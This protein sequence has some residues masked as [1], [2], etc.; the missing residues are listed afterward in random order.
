MG[1]PDTTT[2]ATTPDA[3]GA[4]AVA[5]VDPGMTDDQIKDAIR[6]RYIA[7]ADDAATEFLAD[8]HFQAKSLEEFKSLLQTAPLGF[9]VS[10]DFADRFARLRTEVIDEIA[11]E[12]IP[13]PGSKPLYLV[14]S[15][16]PAPTKKNVERGADPVGLFDG[17]F[18]YAVV[19]I[20]LKG[21]GQDFL[22]VRQYS[23]LATYSGPLGSNWDHNYNLWLS[24]PP[25]RLKIQRSDGA[26][27]VDSFTRHETL[28]YW[29]PP[30]GV[31]GVLLA[32]GDSFTLR[33][34][35]GTRVAYQPH[36]TLGPAIHLVARIE[37]P[38]GND[39][40]FFYDNSRLV[41][42]GVNHAERFVTFAYD[43]QDRIA[44]IRDFTSRAWR[45]DYDDAGN[46]S[47]VTLPA[48]D[49]NKR[50]PTTLYDYLG[51]MT[52]DEGLSHALVTIFDAN[53]RPFLENEYGTDAG[54]VSFR[55]VVRQRQGGG[56]TL[57]DYADVV[58]DFDQPYDDHER[59]ARQT[60]VTERDGRQMRY[61]FNRFGNMLYQ[62][63][64]AFLDG[65]PKLISTH[66][67]YNRD[68]N[69]IASAS[70]IGV[71]IQTLFGRDFYER[72]HPRGADYRPEA[73][74]NLTIEA[75]LQ[76]GN[77][78]AVVKRGTFRTFAPGGSAPGLWSA[79]ALP[80]I[81][82]TDATDAI[83]K[84]TYEP[85]F[86][87]PLTVSDPRFTRSANPAFDEDAEYQRRLTRYTYSPGN[88]FQSLRLQSVQRPTPT[89]PDGTAGQPVVTTFLQYDDR[90]RLLLVANP[91]G[92]QTQ[93]IYFSAADG[94]L[95]G[96]LKAMTIDPAGAALTTAMDRDV[97]G[98]VTRLFRPKHRSGDDDR[99][100]SEAEYN[101]LSQVVRQ[102]STGPFRIT[103][104][105]AYDRA[106]NLAR[107]ELG[108]KD[109]ANTPSGLL[110]TANRYD[111][112]A[113]LVRQ[114]IGDENQSQS[115]T[116]K[117]V[118]DRASRPC[119]TIQ[120]SGRLRKT[121]YNERSLVAAIIEDYAGI[122]AATRGFYD[123]DGRL[124]R[125]IDPRGF[126]TRFT[127]DAL[128]HQVRSEDPLGNCIVR[129]F[130]KLGNLL[131]DCLYERQADGGFLLLARRE[132]NYDELGRMVV[133]SA[134]RFDDPVAVAADQLQA[135]FRDNGPGT[136]LTVRSV[137][138]SAGNLVRREDQDGRLFISEF[139]LL[140]RAVRRQD[141][142][143][144]EWRFAYDQEAIIVR[145]DRQ[146]LV[147]DPT[148]GTVV[149]SQHF[150]ETYTYDELNRMVAQATPVGAITYAHNSRND[151]VRITDPLGNSISNSYDIFRRLTRNRQ[152]LPAAAP[153]GTPTAVDV[154]FAYDRDDQKIA[155]TDALGRITGFSYD[156]AGRLVSTILP[157]GSADLCQYDA[158]GNLIAYRDRNGA[159]RQLTWDALNRM[160]G[161]QVDRSGLAP[162]IALGGATTGVA[163]YDA[164]GR[165][166]HVRND[167]VDTRFRHDSL[168]HLL[169][170]AVTFAGVA[171]A[172]PTRT[173]SIRREFSPTGAVT[174][175]TYP[176]GRAIRYE[177]DILDRVTRIAQ[178]QKGEHYPGDPALPDS[179]PL[180]DY[181]F[182]GLALARLSR[183]DGPTTDL[184][185]DP[186]G[187]LIEVRH[188][189]NDAAILTVQYLHD[190]LGNIRN[191][192]EV[193][194][195]FAAQLAFDYDPL[196]RLVDSRTA[197]AAVLM[198][199]SALEP[200]S[201]PLPDPLPDQ[202][203]AINARFFTLPTA[204]Q[205]S[206]YAYDRAGNRVGQTDGTTVTA[207]TVNAVD[208]YA[209][210]D[211]AALRYDGNGN[212]IEDAA[213]LYGYDF[214]NQLV[215][216]VRK[217]DG[218]E[219]ERVYDCFGRLQAE[220][221]AG[222]LRLFLLDGHEPIEEYE[223]D[224]L[225]LARSTIFDPTLGEALLT[226]G[227]GRD[228]FP[229]CDVRHSVRY[230]FDRSG[231]RNFYIYDPFGGLLQSLTPTDENPFRFAGKRA[232]GE[233][234]KLDFVYR[235]Y[236][237]A[238]GRFLQRDPMGYADGPNLYVFV[239]NNPLAFSDPLGLESRPEFT[240]LSAKFGAEWAYRHPSGFTLTVPDNFDN[241]KI[242]A[243]KERI[244]NPADRG[245]G[246]RS[247]LDNL[248]SSTDDIRAEY[249]T[250]A[251]LAEVYL[252]AK[253]GGRPPNVN[254]DHT[255]ELQHIIRT[256][257]PGANT[258][259]LKDHRFQDASLNKA[260]GSQGMHVNR[261]Q[262]ANGAPLDTS[263][264][265]V[266]R[267]RDLNRFWNR[268]GYRTV[269]RLWGAWTMFG[270]TLA[271]GFSIPDDIR[272]GH[273]GSAAMDTSGFV[274]GSLEIAG[275]LAGSTRL[276][277]AG[278]WLGAPAAVIG[279]GIL[280]VKIG[281]NLYENY[282]DKEM[283]LDAGEWVRRKTGSEVLGALTASSVAIG[284]A[285]VH[286]P[287]AAIDY[288]SET[289][290]YH[291]SEIDW[292]RTFKP[293][294]WLE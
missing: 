75:R 219:I 210:A 128:G 21:A 132:F 292:G 64:Y 14:G 242:R 207:F 54:L 197:G 241:D 45:Y 272:Q 135:A 273:W 133:A 185:L 71:T 202:Q 149:G 201:Q 228:S 8:R 160:T 284:D 262:R 211:G 275:L 59:P 182:A 148:S 259:R 255:V 22:F 101:A 5:Q 225:A 171:G 99:F 104:T 226:S 162:G 280:G 206:T 41:R 76:F 9:H 172:D 31:D 80:D 93:N 131:A 164:L 261:R 78:L 293:W 137:Y 7:L 153:Q 119:M 106:G 26:L 187:R 159:V 12:I 230:L 198:D 237:P 165:P 16:D 47:A 110:V 97:L 178:D 33:M 136:L 103:T 157:D 176:S 1:S 102:T 253:H 217:Q 95:E 264:G 222:T 290:T 251:D 82:A 246:I 90:G 158:V 140:G 257:A 51:A 267:E 190:A 138:D 39:L 86:S 37:D 181:T 291:P 276:L 89:L 115:K 38:F 221:E 184:R 294:R 266:A 170:E 112:D 144:N 205:V 109:E 232:I 224:G 121:L 180:A 58:E 120:P 42:V 199:L 4:A 60:I 70:P 69:L 44:V 141:P 53:G 281:H 63:Q 161:M 77:L 43:D 277:S 243:Y 94:V 24:V 282:I 214:R 271:S 34:P 245:V 25:D 213:W 233:T 269:N 194:Q 154:N 20:N 73:D 127:Y 10:P 28:D 125:L 11:P 278:R 239:R 156:T 265:G 57:F 163:E 129:H 35:D 88:G 167:F 249:E 268:A 50:G 74:H 48:T 173:F 27:R 52:S 67:R 113:N 108:L 19:D 150:A 18:A 215:R 79:T 250:M 279:S 87:Q 147:K 289:W 29:L 218:H 146:E 212:L 145:M 208:Q 17:E 152:F 114:T 66:Y 288:A 188:A 285:V 68:G 283:C 151:C 105:Y 177:R 209:Q 55:R 191:S 192:V 62:E 143:G 256:G 85:E 134:N 227:A 247:G 13:P 49:P 286:L 83:Q 6:K 203:A 100:V 72:L 3:G 155:Q 124:I 166:R 15:T 142:Y 229:L 254:L 91:L 244:Q 61:L 117:V 2:P 260:Q 123:A 98:R 116:I 235:A 174:R 179:T 46:L 220:R 130:D 168:D 65:L 84:F 231:K 107:T 111:D 183:T 200:S 240:P 193:A 56:D 169:E 204:T 23:Q 81:F 236:D 223:G 238:L 195:D 196:S 175:L 186:D 258:V 263:A 216:A 270:G 122:R 126:V 248:R 36:P 92:L 274:G 234:G 287:E 118:F 252:R 189:S 40:A 139:D 30:D 32:E 96:H